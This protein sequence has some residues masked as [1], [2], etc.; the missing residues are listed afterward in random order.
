MKKKSLLFLF[1]FILF[2]GNAYAQKPLNDAMSWLSAGI[3]QKIQYKW[4][5]KLLTRFRIGE[6][7]TQL[8]SWY[9]DLGVQY[10]I[11]DKLNVTL[12]YVLAPSRAANMRFNNFHQYYGSINYKI[13]PFKHWEIAD[14]IILQ[15]TSSGSVMDSGDPSK[16]STDFRNKLE[17]GRKFNKHYSAF[18]AD[19][20]LLPLSSTP[21][22]IKRNRFYAGINRV[23]TKR[24]NLDMYF[25]LQSSYHSS[26]Q[27]NR[28][29]IYGLDFNY[30]LRRIL[31]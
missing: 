31:L 18:M 2:S 29:Y 28:Y 1:L 5:V 19:E 21:F 15:R 30:K 7:F 8:N 23:I 17:I 13:K 12:N 6:N 9:S 11:N 3:N 22:E 16:N 27:N 10:D 26:S 14:R 25:V 20:V 24:I 4:G